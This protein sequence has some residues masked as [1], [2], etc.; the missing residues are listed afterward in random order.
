MFLNKEKTVLCFPKF[1]WYSNVEH[2]W[3]WHIWSKFVVGRF[4]YWY[5]VWHN[6]LAEFAFCHF[7]W[8][9]KYCKAGKKFAKHL[10]MHHVQFNPYI[11]VSYCVLWLSIH[12]YLYVYI[13]T[14]LS[15]LLSFIIVWIGRL[16]SNININSVN[17]SDK[18]LHFKVLDNFLL[19]SKCFWYFDS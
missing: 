17:E 3:C 18:R 4:R 13:D 5:R 14:D 12:T 7:T 11:F 1:W 9:Q 6:I 2:L 10:N 19:F 15:R 16:S 8:S